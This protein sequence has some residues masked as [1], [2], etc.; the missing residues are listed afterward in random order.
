M[1]AI[2]ISRSVVCTCV[3]CKRREKVREAAPLGVV[4]VQI[5]AL[6]AS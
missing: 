1:G 2:S 4:L 3:L 5:R 6:I